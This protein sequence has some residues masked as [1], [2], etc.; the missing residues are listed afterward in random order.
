MFLLF[1]LIWSNHLPI[2]YKFLE[3]GNKNFGIFVHNFSA[4]DSLNSTQIEDDLASEAANLIG[5]LSRHSLDGIESRQ[6]LYGP[7]LDIRP[8]DLPGAVITPGDRR[9][10]GTD[11]DDTTLIPISGVGRPPIPQ[12]PEGGWID[13]HLV[14]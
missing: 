11:I 2:C 8:L 1:M 9:L 12:K 14:N 13:L 6:N 5:S 4:R 3:F 7:E 10:N